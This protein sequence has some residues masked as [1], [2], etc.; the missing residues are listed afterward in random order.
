MNI[1]KIKI[2]LFG[3]CLSLVFAELHAKLDPK[4]AIVAH[5]NIYKT[6]D[7]SKDLITYDILMG[8]LF[9]SAGIHESLRL[10]NPN[11]KQI[12]Y[13][14]IRDTAPAASSTA[15]TPAPNP[16]RCVRLWEY[17]SGDEKNGKSITRGGYSVT[18]TKLLFPSHQGFA[19]IAQGS[20]LSL[21][22]LLK[23]SSVENAKRLAEI[24]DI[25]KQCRALYKTLRGPVQRNKKTSSIISDN[26]DFFEK[27][28]LSEP[29][30]ILADRLVEKKL[31]NPDEAKNFFCCL[32]KLGELLNIRKQSVEYLNTQC[33]K[34]WR[35]SIGNY[36]KGTPGKNTSIAKDV[37]EIIAKEGDVNIKEKYLLATTIGKN[38]ELLLSLYNTCI[39]DERTREYCQ[40]TMG[41][42]IAKCDQLVEKIFAS[43]TTNK[44]DARSHAT[45]FVIKL[46]KSIM[47][48]ILCEDADEDAFPPY[49]AEHMFLAFCCEYMEH[50]E[51]LE[52]FYA[53]LL[54]RPLFQPSDF[55]ELNDTKLKSLL[56]EGEQFDED[57]ADDVVS[58]LI[59][60]AKVDRIPYDGTIGSHRKARAF[61]VDSDSQLTIWDH[62]TGDCA[63]TVVRH[64]V[65]LALYDPDEKKFTIAAP[66]NEKAKDEL[67]TAIVNY[68]TTHHINDLG[69]RIK[70]FYTCQ[71]PSMT[72][73]MDEVLRTF[74]WYAIGNLGESSKNSAYYAIRY[75]PNYRNTQ[76]LTPGF[77]NMLK[78]LFNIAT[79]IATRDSE[80]IRKARE[81]IDALISP[82]IKQREIYS[83]E[84]KTK[85]GNALENVMELFE[86]KFTFKLGELTVNGSG[87]TSTDDIFGTFPIIMT[88][89]GKNQ[90]TV[91]SFN[92]NHAPCH[93]QIDAKVA[94]PYLSMDKAKTL[95]EKMKEDRYIINLKKKIGTFYSEC[96]YMKIRNFS[97]YEH[98]LYLFAFTINPSTG[99]FLHCAN[100]IAQQFNHDD[101]ISKMQFYSDKLFNKEYPADY[102][103]GPYPS[104]LTSLNNFYRRGENIHELNSDS[105][106]LLAEMLQIP[107]KDSSIL[108]KSVGVD[109]EFFS[110]N[111]EKLYAIHLKVNLISELGHGSNE[112]TH[113]IYDVV[114]GSEIFA[115]NK[116]EEFLFLRHHLGLQKLTTVLLDRLQS[117][118]PED[119][120]DMVKEF[121]KNAPENPEE[122]SN[123]FEIAN[124]MK[125]T[126]NQEEYSKK[127]SDIDKKILKKNFDYKKIINILPDV[128]KKGIPQNMIPH[129]VIFAL[130]QQGESFKNVVQRIVNTGTTTA[131]YLKT[132][133][134]YYEANGSRISKDKM[135]AMCKFRSDISIDDVMSLINYVST[136][137]SATMKEVFLEL[138]D[139]RLA[140]AD[141][142][143]TEHVETI[144]E[145]YGAN[146]SHISKDQMIAMCN[147]RND[148]SI[149]DIM[150][151]ANYVSTRGS[152]T[153]KEVFLELV[154]QKLTQLKES[155]TPTTQ[156][157]P[158]M[159]NPDEET[160][161]ILTE[162]MVNHGFFTNE[163]AVLH[164]LQARYVGVCNDLLRNAKDKTRRKQVLDVW[165][166]I[167]AST[168]QKM[169]FVE[170]FWN[171]LG[172]WADDR[173]LEAVVNTV[174]YIVRGFDKGSRDITV[175]NS[176]FQAFLE[177]VI[178]KN[179]NKLELNEKE[180]TLIEAYDDIKA[181]KSES[182]FEAYC[183]F[184][185]NPCLEKLD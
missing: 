101:W 170:L 120:Q 55:K 177:A 140:N 59:S 96:K 103:Y 123:Y 48:T 88:E 134:E 27:I 64:M 15:I 168:K 185:P 121:L 6:E 172:E 148:I 166:H 176:Y 137:G 81:S 90:E 149:N 130:H 22:G 138:V 8:Q 167:V 70:L 114:Q 3:S 104:V 100:T 153:M 7:P 159:L 86:G 16:S 152:A 105:L 47:A 164:E 41:E 43:N 75:N 1:K 44:G 45:S 35:K 33:G 36:I 93:S 163:T 178:N 78:I 17:D 119:C 71:P 124:L 157:F 150:N 89:K 21:S 63:D 126:S 60:Q 125:D 151:L 52:A 32:N 139:P 146:N 80:K 11:L 76:E 108:E 61:S 82:Q 156:L 49:T 102:G 74:W 169:L 132:I 162:L 72:N 91:F 106:D 99:I 145:Y 38:E 79:S 128:I 135:V 39:K 141:A 25:I 84:V 94:R 20:S 14:R 54:D 19:S 69:E 117:R 28:L 12:V 180:R 160:F 10:N 9:V 143:T 116:A 171:Y 30:K 13:G 31:I 136:K 58:L 154:E 129:F 165:P 87:L 46:Q 173:S 57:S 56:V 40:R 118:E 179:R 131:E 109:R 174:A 85:I 175:L 77:G 122:L 113:N 92:I 68:G 51:E 24:F 2:F 42:I 155:R 62:T 73:N 182:W 34:D 53:K 147:L 111:K 66:Q 183:L 184:V 127:L 4:L 181:S 158:G 97:H 115:K 98:F 161:L 110:K 144:F 67:I 18:F 65:N 50:E 5:H 26:I 112:T 95:I 107:A 37:Q 142:T 83:D 23:G 29:E 133:F